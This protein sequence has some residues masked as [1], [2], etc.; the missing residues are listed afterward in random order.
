MLKKISFSFLLLLLVLTLMPQPAKATSTG[1]QPGTLI[2]GT[3]PSIYYYGADN[4]RYVFPNEKT[5]KTW[6]VTFNVVVAISNELLGEIPI[7]GNV[8]YKPGVKLVK[9]TTD[10]KVYYV[11]KEGTL[12]HISS[13]A[14]AKQLWGNTWYT[15][16]DD[17]PDPFFINY[18]IGLPLKD[19]LFT[20]VTS[21]YFLN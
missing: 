12:R 19:S 5:Y 10:P 3:T 16:V 20:T 14:L 13:E 7:G 2:K 9:I 15:L 6:F 1:L 4:K 11:D 18:K 21:A 8:T 17:V